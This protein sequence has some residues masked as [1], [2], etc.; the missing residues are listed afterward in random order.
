MKGQEIV[1]SRPAVVMGDV[2]GDSFALHVLLRKIREQFGQD[3]DIYHVGDIVDRGEGSKEVVQLCIDN[4]IQGVLGNHETWMHQVFA[5]GEF[6]PFALHK[7]MGGIPTLKSYGVT[8]FKNPD[9]IARQLKAKV[10]QAH[11]D[12]ILGLP[13]WRKFE[14]DGVT[15]RLVHAGVK[16]GEAKAFKADAKRFADQEG[17]SFDDALCDRIATVKPAY[18]LWQGPNL[19]QHNLYHFPDGSVQ[20]FGHTPRHDVTMT[21]RFI[22]VDTGCG[23]CPPYR[24]SAVVLPSRE[25]ITATRLGDKIPAGGGFGKFGLG[26]KG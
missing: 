9:E 16:Q 4:N 18:M 17:I 26:K 11:K 25:V 6:D 14:V 22:A 8:E 1:M 15:Y 5:T 19:N 24:L 13:L 7:V 23:T 10:P 12:Y 21:K 20:I 3:V 2:Q